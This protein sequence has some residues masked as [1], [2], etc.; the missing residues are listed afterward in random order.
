[1][2]IQRNFRYQ[3]IQET[4]TILVRLSIDH[5]KIRG[6]LPALDQLHD[7]I[8]KGVVHCN[9]KVFARRWVVGRGKRIPIVRPGAIE[10]RSFKSN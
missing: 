9:G 10:Q 7:A 6:V 3:Q 5:D 4:S 1:M 8:L 2:T